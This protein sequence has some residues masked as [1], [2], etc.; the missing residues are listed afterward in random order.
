MSEI[1]EQL[2]EWEN[3]VGA[4][5][6]ASTIQ[7][8]LKAKTVNNAWIEMTDNKVILDT[9]KL[10]LQLNWVK[11]WSSVNINL[12]NVSKPWKDENLNY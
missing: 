11:V 5:E 3:K 8:L 10:V 1:M 6:I 2:Q 7:S 4:T 9:V 12:F